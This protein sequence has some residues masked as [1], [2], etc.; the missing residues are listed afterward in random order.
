M[1]KINLAIQIFLIIG[2]IIVS[3]GVAWSLNDKKTLKSDTDIVIEL[4]SS[5][6]VSGKN[7]KVGD[8]AT[9]KGKDIDLILSIDNMILGR[10]PWPGNNRTLGLGDI[11]TILF[12]RGVDLS[13]VRFKGANE[14]TVKV[15][16]IVISGEEIAN[17]AEK[18][19]R[20]K[21]N[22]GKDEE[23]VVELQHI[24]ED[25]IVPLGDGNVKLRFSRTSMGKSKKKVYLSINIVVNGN[26]YTTV[27]LMFN[28]KRFGSVVVTERVIKSGDVIRKGAVSLES[29]ETTELSEDAFNNVEDVIGKVAKRSLRPGQ[30]VTGKIVENMSAMK[31]GDIVVILIKSS[32]LEVTAKGICQED[33][34][35]GDMVKVV[36]ID[37]KKVLY[38]SVLDSGTVEIQS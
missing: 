13:G 18:Y 36:N 4:K 6:I 30:I 29:V 21:L 28:I 22:H 31:K 19:L 26:V 33:G 37:T 38:G 11:M 34:A 27:G 12:N 8:V 2:L 35:Y 10:A 15:K 32:G 17:H 23:A 3:S 7:I 1:K 25:Q 20:N 16:S 9:V 24:P 5:A 14:V